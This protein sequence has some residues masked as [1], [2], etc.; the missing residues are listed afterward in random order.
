MPKFKFTLEKVLR[1]REF[2]EEQAKV[3]LGKAIQETERIKQTLEYV[4]KQRVKANHDLSTTI[5]IIQLQSYQNYIMGLDAQKD[6]LLEQLAQ[7]ELVVEEKRLLLT[8]AMK[9]RKALDKMKEKQLE[10]FKKDQE[11][12]EENF[13]DDMQKKKAST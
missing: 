9:K 5:D 6:Q 11:R 10:Q 12:I 4:A 3:E 7:A 13:L 8:E 1:I 2:E